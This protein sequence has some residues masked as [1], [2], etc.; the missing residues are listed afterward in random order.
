M[1]SLQIIRRCAVMKVVGYI[2]AVLN[3]PSILFGFF[4]IGCPRTGPGLPAIIHVPFASLFSLGLFL[5][6]ASERNLIIMR[7]N[8]EGVWQARRRS[9]F[10]KSMLVPIAFMIFFSVLMMLRDHGIL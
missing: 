7:E 5:I 8:G 1:N 9:T 2:L 10:L 3:V 4:E 6:I